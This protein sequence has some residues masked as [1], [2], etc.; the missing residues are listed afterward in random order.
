MKMIVWLSRC[1]YC[2]VRQLKAHAMLTMPKLFL[3][4]TL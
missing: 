1:A 4:C 2:H 3:H